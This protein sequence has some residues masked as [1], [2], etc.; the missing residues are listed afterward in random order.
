VRKWQKRM[1]AFV[2]TIDALVAKSPFTFIAI[3][4]RPEATVCEGVASVTEHAL[5]QA[6]RQSCAIF[7]VILRRYV[8]IL[9]LAN[10][11]RSAIPTTNEPMGPF[12]QVTAT[13]GRMRGIKLGKSG[14]P[15]AEP[16]VTATSQSVAIETK[17]N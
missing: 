14:V 10:R 15:K 9:N 13:G 6:G 3:F 11:F 7:A 17:I 5:V 4:A 2:V 16:V 8:V 12:N 1:G